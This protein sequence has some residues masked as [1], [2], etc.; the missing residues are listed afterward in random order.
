MRGTSSTGREGRAAGTY[1]LREGERAALLAAQGGK[2]AI[3]GW[4]TGRRA[5]VVDHDHGSGEVRG[6]L[7]NL[8]NRV[9]GF[10]RD[11]S[12]VFECFA[13]Y[14]RNPPAR[15]VLPGRDWSPYRG[16]IDDA[17]RTSRLRAGVLCTHDDDDD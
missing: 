6:L 8:C 2:C 17:E 3:C 13:E 12:R 7:C 15:R 11:R 5:R 10:Y 4:L 9:I 14:L 1:G 16:S